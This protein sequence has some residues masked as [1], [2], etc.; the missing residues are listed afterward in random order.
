[1]K[2]LLS[3]PPSLSLCLSQ[4][5]LFTGASLPYFLKTFKAL[6]YHL[7]WV[8]S[9]QNYQLAALQLPEIFWLAS[10]LHPLVSGLSNA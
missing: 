8:P 1:M 7:N 2:N 4:E 6:Y 3:L 5:K 9:L 10:R